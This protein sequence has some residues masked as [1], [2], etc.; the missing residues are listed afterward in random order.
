MNSPYYKLLPETP[1]RLG[2]HTTMDSSSHPPK[3]GNL[4]FEF[5][6]W[7]GD[8]LVECFPCYFIT[9]RLSIALETAGLSGFM[10]KEAQISYSDTFHELYPDR[11]MPSFKSIEIFGKIGDDFFIQK[12]YLVVSSK[13]LTM[14]RQNGRMKYCEVEELST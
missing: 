5:D 7:L 3:I 2:K 1:G 14:L 13:G 10:I 4:H 12:N 6:G 11:E 8:E 9:E